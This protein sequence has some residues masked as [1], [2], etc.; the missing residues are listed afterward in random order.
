MWT[1]SCAPGQGWS[2]SCPAVDLLL[3]FQVY[4]SHNKDPVPSRLPD[5][6]HQVKGIKEASA[7]G[8]VFLDGTTV[9][10]NALIFATG[11]SGS[12]VFVR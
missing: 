6:V 9:R 7:D 10:A 12:S 4:L 5:N 1:R 11:N 8:F 3:A 2:P